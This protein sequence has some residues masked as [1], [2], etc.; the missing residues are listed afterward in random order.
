[1][2]TIVVAVIVAAAVG[3]TINRFVKIYKGEGGCSCDSGC[4]CSSKDSCTKDLPMMMK[5]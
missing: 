5:K 1:M 2:D 4:A 3:F